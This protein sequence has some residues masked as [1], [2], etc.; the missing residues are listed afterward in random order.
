[1]AGGIEG[2]IDRLDAQAALSFD[3]ELFL[4]RALGV[5]DGATI[6]EVGAG[7]GAVTTRLL[8]AFPNSPLV[9]LEPDPVLRSAADDRLRDHAIDAGRVTM[10]DGVCE[11]IPLPDLSIDLAFVRFVLQHLADPVAAAL[12]VRRVLKPGGR[13][14][15]VDFDGELW[16]LSAPYNP[17]LMP[18]HARVFAAQSDRGG[19]RFI[20]RDLTKILGAAGFVDTALHAFAVSSDEVGLE[21]FAPIIGPENLLPHLESGLIS[22]SEYSRV[23]RD[24]QR[25]VA[26]PDHVVIS[27]GFLGTGLKP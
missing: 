4:L 6:L 18:I 7:S 15:V 20:G 17:E 25:F 14:V 21:P 9:A 3:K 22:M 19:N 16:G 23:L 8:E 26:D 12:E 10:L 2:E 5:P 11:Q 27:M 1:M 24:Y 13:I